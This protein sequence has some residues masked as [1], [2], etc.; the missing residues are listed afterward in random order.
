MRFKK[1]TYYEIYK[2]YAI[3]KI[4]HEEYKSCE[5]SRKF[6]EDIVNTKLSDTHPHGNK[7]IDL[8]VTIP[9]TLRIA[10]M[11]N[12]ECFK[13]VSILSKEQSEQVFQRCL[14]D[15]NNKKNTPKLNGASTLRNI[16]KQN[17]MFFF[18]WL[19][20]ELYLKSLKYLNQRFYVLWHNEK[21]KSYNF[22]MLDSN[23]FLSLLSK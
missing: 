1:E 6:Y 16:P 22:Y 3:F 8:S 7:R 10:E 20:F 13:K 15:I 2:P 5:Y 17:R 14:K 12:N 11:E 23:M 19:I 18:I 4:T 21:K 9:L